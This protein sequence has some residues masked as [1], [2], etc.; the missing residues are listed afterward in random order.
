MNF[1]FRTAE[2]E[3]ISQNRKHHLK[4]IKLADFKDELFP[5][6]PVSTAGKEIYNAILSTLTTIIFSQ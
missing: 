4:Q 2:N 3:K 5:L 6:L 1:V